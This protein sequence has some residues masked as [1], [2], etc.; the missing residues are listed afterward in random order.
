MLEPLPR[1]PSAVDACADT[2]RRAIVAGDL[3]AGSRLPA[4]RD[5]ATRLG[6]NRTTLRSALHEVARDG[7][8]EVRHGSGYRVADLR[9]AGG[10]DLVPALVDRART[11]GRLASTCAELLA[12]RRGV[13]GA[14]VD[15]LVGVRPTDPALDAVDRA[16]DALDAARGGSLGAVAAADLGVVR[17]WIRAAGSDVLAVFLHPMGRLLAS[18]PELAAAIYADPAVNVALW[19]AMVAAIRT[20]TASAPA[21]IEALRQ[22]DADTVRRLEST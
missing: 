21:L 18:L 16:I 8:L 12:I 1:R 11:E 10:P 5:L 3:P 2:L 20:G 19:R 22:R 6:V 7:L 9:D 15:R 14:L 4:E 17:A 13:A